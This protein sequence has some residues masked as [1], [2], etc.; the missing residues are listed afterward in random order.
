M[1][2]LLDRIPPRLRA[3]VHDWW[4]VLPVLWVGYTVRAWSMYGM[5]N[6][7]DHSVI[8]E[9]A[10]IAVDS[11]IF[12]LYKNSPAGYPPL[13]LMF[14]TIVA[15]IQNVTPY[16][17]FHPL[18]LPLYKLLPIAA[19]LALIL[20]ALVWL[21]AKP[22]LRWVLPL[23]LSLHPGLVAT[24]A[25]WGQSDSIYMLPVVL[26][27][28]AL[29]RDKPLAAWIFFALGMLVKTQTLIILPVLGLLSLRRYGIPKT[30][31]GIAIGAGI[32]IAMMTPFVLNSG[33]DRTVAP[34]LSSLDRFPSTTVNAYNLWEVVAGVVTGN[35]PARMDD[36][37]PVLGSITYKQIGL[38]LFGLSTL[39]VCVSVWRDPKARREFVWGA[40]IY[41]GMFILATQ[42]HERYLYPGVVLVI[43][44]V[45]QERRLWLAALV[46]IFT[47][48]YNVIA[49]TFDPFIFVGIPL[50]LML[51]GISI[52]VALINV[53][54]YLNLMP[55][56]VLREV[57]AALLRALTRVA[58]ALL[59]MVCLVLIG[60]HLGTLSRTAQWMAEHVASGSRIA[61]Q[62]SALGVQYFS[63]SDVARTWE[64]R[65]I[66]F[67]KDDTPSNYIGDGIHYML[68][69]DAGSD[70]F[71]SHLDELIEDGATIRYQSGTMFLPERLA[72]L[73]TF[74]PAVC[75]RAVF[76]NE[77]ELHGYDL[78]ESS[79][80]LYWYTQQPSAVDYQ[81]FLHVVN[82]FTDEL[83]AQ[84][85]QALGGFAHPS[86]GWRKGEIVF[87]PIPLPPEA[88]APYAIVQ[89]GLYELASGRRARLPNLQDGTPR[90]A[91][92]LDLN[93]PRE[94]CPGDPR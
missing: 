6:Y 54:L 41:W 47:Y 69:N 13:F 24:T 93:A 40:G 15:S 38:A 44:A 85:D 76:D 77:L 34:F 8:S 36:T 89:I 3:F 64:W 58:V 9:W 23:I 94:S 91:L 16:D 92:T 79:L 11:G 10:H 90:D 35:P 4:F 21:R 88:R 43:L 30:A 74:S 1:F 56:V 46:S 83:I 65:R 82:R 33:W 7:S 42:M 52:P 75:E 22:I 87:E 48:T 26:V 29:N 59:A 62:D 67:Y 73:W 25:F 50:Y 68:I 19:E 80:L 66:G 55:V 32:G 2:A 20:V 81:V 86:S 63:T 39:L 70:A 18:I 57:K 28:I 17:N 84:S 49:V 60:L 78:Q 37:L 12:N 53:L 72:V 14:T 5:G 71:V 61:H 51:A 45:A 31:L 27:L